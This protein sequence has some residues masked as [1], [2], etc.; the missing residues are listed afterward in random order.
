MPQDSA[1]RSAPTDNT[2]DLSAS[3]PKQPNIGLHSRLS[4]LPQGVPSNVPYPP[5][6]PQSGYESPPRTPKGHPLPIHQGDYLSRSSLIGFLG[7]GGTGIKQGMT[8]IGGARRSSAAGGKFYPPDSTTTSTNNKPRSKF[9]S[10]ISYL[11]RGIPRKIRTPLLCLV[12]LILLGT[13][14][15]KIAHERADTLARMQAKRFAANLQKAYIV[16]TASPLAHGDTSPQNEAAAAAGSRVKDAG[17]KSALQPETY[18]T[19][20]AP[21]AKE[22][23]ESLAAVVPFDSS[24]VDFTMNAREETAALISFITSTSNNALP[25]TLDPSLPLDP[26]LVL[27]FDFTRPSARA[28][29]SALVADTFAM[30]PVVL[31]GQMRDPYYRE[32][33]KLFSGYVVHPAPLVVEVDQRADEEIILALLQRLLGIKELPVL[34]LNGQSA[35][36]W[37]QIQETADNGNFMKLIATRSSA[38]IQEKKLKKRPKGVKD[39]ERRENERILKPK[40]IVED[41]EEVEGVAES[42]WE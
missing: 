24:D 5:S 26:Q 41:V 21:P 12:C 31:F 2:I 32:M 25:A 20:V 22:A 37:P 16:D 6:P 18:R 29:L 39:A 30:Y 35:G 42:R 7:G 17:S 40:P 15:L 23:A 8:S 4:A 14:G 27:D 28:D 13:V 19:R 9:T 11:T 3:P 1:R 36:T 33:R 34:M 38:K 10:T